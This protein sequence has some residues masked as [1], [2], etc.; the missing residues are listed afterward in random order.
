MLISSFLLTLPSAIVASTDLPTDLPNNL[1]EMS[2]PSNTT[3][4]LANEQY[5]GEMIFQDIRNQLPLN[6][7]LFIEDYINRL[8]QKLAHAEPHPNHHFH[9]FV[10][11]SPE[12]N[13]VT[14][15]G[16]YIG[17]NTGLIQNAQTEGELASVLAHEIGHVTE[18]H[19]ARNIAEQ[20]QLQI[21]SLMGMLGSLVLAAYSPAAAQGLFTSTIALSTQSALNFTRANEV[22]ADRAG[23]RT[24]IAAGYDPNLMAAFFQRLDRYSYE[25]DLQIPEYLR[26]HPTNA[27][28]IADARNLAQQYPHAIPRPPS[29]DFLL[30]QKRIALQDLDL[31][32][33]NT[34]SLETAAKT[35][36]TGLAKIANQYALAMNYIKKHDPEKAQ[37]LIHTL[38]GTLP[39]HPFIVDLKTEQMIL[40]TQKENALN[41]LKQYLKNPPQQEALYPLQIKY[42]T[43]ALSS[44]HPE[45]AIT[46]LKPLTAGEAKHTIETL[47][48]DLLLAEAYNAHQELWRAQL[49]YSHYLKKTG[50][51][52]SAIAQLESAIEFNKLTPDQKKVFQS[53]ISTLKK[54]YTMRKERMK[55]L[56]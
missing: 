37:D 22:E 5:L 48:A 30:I 47:G 49:S 28:R 54:E 33:K 6:H 24:L 18:R 2:S 36:Q 25:Q 34:E 53:Q 55:E 19:F 13:A 21:P 50:D 35:D 12:I 16:G 14:L 27:N 46:I 9:F 26:T 43:L 15:P 20:K 42:A 56:M 29:L 3:L 31:P 8:G 11:R 40:T 39:Q 51:Y 44:Q 23:I 7:D 52:S 38:Q 41:V 17:V 10:I 4:S 32:S 1:P 45:Q